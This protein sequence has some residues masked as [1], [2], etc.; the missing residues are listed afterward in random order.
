MLTDEIV[1]IHPPELPRLLYAN[2]CGEILD[3]DDLGMAGKAG[4]WFKQPALSDIIP[5][6]ADSEIFVLPDRSPVG[7]DLNTGEA[8]LVDTNPV[9]PRDKI[10]AVAA[11]MAPAHTAIYSAAF[12]K[13][14]T[15]PANLPLFAYTAVGW[16]DDKFWVCGF[17]SD[18]D[19]RQEFEQIS[20]EKIQ[21]NTQQSLNKYKKNRLIQHLGK[22]C[23]TYGCPAAKNLFLGR[24]EAPLPTSPA[25]NAKCVG[26]ISLQPSGCCPATQDRIK[27][28]PT[29]QE[30]AE[31]AIHHLTNEPNGIVSFGQGC[32]GEPLLQADI[33]A[34]AIK[35]I[36]AK[37]T[38]GTI[39]LN[40]NSSLPAAVE[41]LVAA[42]LDSIR[43]SINSAR[44]GCHTLY[45]RPEGFNF[46][47]VK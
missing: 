31:V 4:Q 21:H 43:V 37:K 27:F 6:P 30:I 5:L 32:E 47:N 15:N 38:T 29:P 10:H 42:G 25:C 17:R 41:D 1:N 46:N 7:S 11:F 28:T 16:L 2:G 35:L 39:N 23:L 22:C 19:T 45:Y 20:P 14:E 26:C 33:I 9:D 34:K 40:S 24:F 44:K 18:D 13:N 36:R 3:I 8:I 12:E